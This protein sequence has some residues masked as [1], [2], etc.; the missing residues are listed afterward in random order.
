MSTRSLQ[1][2]VLVVGVSIVYSNSLNASFHFDDNYMIVNNPLVHDIK[3]LPLILKDLFHRPLLKATF[4]LNYQLGGLDVTGY[5]LVN[6]L[7]HLFVVFEVYILSGLLLREFS[8][9]PYRE[10]P[11]IAS[12]IFALHP[13]HTGSVTYISSRSSVLLTGLLLLSFILFL[14]ASTTGKRALKI[15]SFGVFIL[16]FGVK[17]TIVVLP[18]LILLY[19][20]IHERGV[21]LLKGNRLMLAVLF[22]VLGTYLLLRKLTLSTVA[23]VDRRIYE[24]LLPPLQYLLTEIK[25]I[26]LYYLKWL[27]IPVGGPYVDPDIPAERTLLSLPV[28]AS[29]AII[30]TLTAIAFYYRKRASFVSFCI[31]WFFI[32]L[33]PTSSIFP[34]GDLA[35]QRRL[36]LPTVGFSMVMAYLICALLRHPLRLM[37]AVTSLALFLGSVTYHDNAIWKTELTLWEDAAR[38]SPNKVRVLNNRAYAYLLEGDL[39][40]AEALYRELLQRFPEY[41]YGHYNLG[42]IYHMKG[43]LKEA[44][45]EYRV[46]INLRPG[47]PMF[48]AKLALAYDAT[49]DLDLALVEARRAVELSPNNSELLTILGSLLAKKGQFTKAIEVSRKAIALNPASPMAYYVLGYSYEQTS[50]IDGAIEAYRRAI[51]L[52]PDWRLPH[53]RLLNLTR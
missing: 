34:L 1:L 38:K 5:H 39:D 37:P 2:T 17:E 50:N 8:E 31:L 19:I 49:G 36:Y 3:N 33:L 29:L 53:Q 7:M 46:A 13:V 44:I 6:L 52:K 24:G 11:F 51:Q 18:F 20:Y 27:I 26:G 25:V 32:S 4:L 43:R 35:Q 16:G 22:I 40:R 14:K 41:P 30:I 48:R 21:D 45:E 10:L 9:R 23:P 47:N 15:A 12:L 28:M 42:S